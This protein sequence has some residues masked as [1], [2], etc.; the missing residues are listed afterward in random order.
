MKKKWMTFACLLILYFGLFY[1]FAIRSTHPLIIRL[2]RMELIS[3]MWIFLFLHVFIDVHRL[4][5]FLFKYRWFFALGIFIFLVIHHIHFSSV[6]MFHQYIQ[7]NFGSPLVRPILGQSLPIRSDEWNYGVP[8]VFAAYYSGFRA[9]SDIPRA[10]HTASLAATGYYFSFSSLAFMDSLGY[11]LFGPEIGISFSW[12]FRLVLV[13][14]F[15]YELCLI[16]TKGKRIVSLFGTSLILSGPFVFWSMFAL[17][18]YGLGILVCFYYFI[19]WRS[20]WARFGIGIVL[21]LCTAGFICYLYPAWQVPFG[22]IILSILAYEL[23]EKR[24]WQMFKKVDWLIFV[25]CFGF[26]VAIVGSFVIDNLTYINS[27]SNTVYPG[28]REIDGGFGLFEMLGYSRQLFAP[29]LEFGNISEDSTFIGVFP[30]GYILWFLAQKKAHFRHVF[31]WFVFPVLI[32]LTAYCLVPLP[33]FL[34]K[35]LMLTTSMPGRTADFLGLLLI[36]ICVVYFAENH[37]LK[38]YQAGLIAFG[39]IAFEIYGEWTFL[40]AIDLWGFN[41]YM[42]LFIGVWIG[43]FLFLMFSLF[44]LQKTKNWLLG[45]GGVGLL[46]FGLHVNPMMISLDAITSK[47]V[48]QKVRQIVQAEKGST[49]LGLNNIILPQY[50]I[51]AGAPTLNST[52]NIPNVELWKKLDPSGQNEFVY[53]RYAHLAVTLTNSPTSF[54]LIAND[55]IGLQLNIEDARDLGINYVLTYDELDQ[56]FTGLHKIYD[57]DQIRI[58]QF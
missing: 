49:W 35:I 4:Y 23:Y 43:Y 38:W 58:Y 21:A 50:L 11:Y 44:S 3:L 15:G 28:H 12:S 6:G 42:L 24:P 39:C 20:S 8:R 41:R 34:A 27:I 10:T 53:L 52:Q 9:F 2:I 17:L 32:G 51:S 57:E 1:M 54:S 33:H 47:P 19:S 7:P 5:D 16:L 13:L 26:M 56:E 37:S 14:F 46:I 45:I 29:R 36:L 25:G 55:V 31:M 22:W 30:L 40:K 48:Y 18:P